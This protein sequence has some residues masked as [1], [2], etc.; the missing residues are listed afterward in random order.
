MLLGGFPALEASRPP[1]RIKDVDV[2]VWE[3]REEAREEVREEAREETR[4]REET[5]EETRAMY[6]RKTC[7]VDAVTLATIN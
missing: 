1:Q 4:T 3:A 7:V 6:R 5:R 2:E